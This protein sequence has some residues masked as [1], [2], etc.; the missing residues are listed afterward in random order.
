MG[1]R[2]SVRDERHYDNRSYDEVPYAAPLALRAVRARIHR[3]N[4]IIETTDALVAR[5][6]TELDANS[7][8]MAAPAPPEALERPAEDPPEELH[9]LPRRRKL[10]SAAIEAAADEAA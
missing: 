1:E 8:A 10:A 6:S 3:R 4:P 2:A 9:S 7:R 5:I